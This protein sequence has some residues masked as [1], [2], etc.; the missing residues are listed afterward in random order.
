MYHTTQ[1]FSAF[2]RD[3]HVTVQD[4]KGLVPRPQMPR[5]TTPDRAACQYRVRDVAAKYI[6]VCC[7]DRQKLY[8]GIY[9]Y[10]DQ[11]P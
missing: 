9:G 1:D 3:M 6:Q 11:G 7:A 2:C 4:D 8:Q 10:A 5:A